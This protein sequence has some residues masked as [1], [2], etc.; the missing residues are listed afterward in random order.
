M[1]ALLMEAHMRG[2]HLFGIVVAVLVVL[3]LLKYLIR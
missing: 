3:A 2:P 1:P